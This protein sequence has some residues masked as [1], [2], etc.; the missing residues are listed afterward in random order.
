MLQPLAIPEFFRQEH[1]PPDGSHL[2]DIYSNTRWTE[3]IAHLSQF[4][5]TS[6]PTTKTQLLELLDHEANPASRVTLMTGV[7]RCQI[8]EGKLFDAAQ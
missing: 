3:F 5:D 2:P 6:I 4:S 8:G 7:A 1:Q